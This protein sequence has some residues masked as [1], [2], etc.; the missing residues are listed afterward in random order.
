MMNSEVATMRPSVAA[1]ARDQVA[2]VPAW[3][4]STATA[5]ATGKMRNPRSA[6]DGNGV[7][8]P[9]TISLQLQ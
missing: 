5:T 8:R 9:A 6:G 4:N 7:S 1:R 3:K 2:D